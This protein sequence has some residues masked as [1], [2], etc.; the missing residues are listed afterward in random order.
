M[1]KPIK[2]PKIIPD[3]KQT[4]NGNTENKEDLKSHE[5]QVSDNENTEKKKPKKRPK[6]RN[7][8]GGKGNGVKNKKTKKNTAHSDGKENKDKNVSDT[9]VTASTSTA[10]SG[11]LRSRTISTEIPAGPNSSQETQFADKIEDIYRCKI[12]DQTFKR[13]L[14]M[15]K[16][17]LTCT[18][19]GNKFSCEVC[20]KGF[21]QKSYC[22]QHFDFY[23][24]NKPKKFVCTLCEKSFPLKKTLQ[25]HN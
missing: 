5:R 20:G 11:T 14:Q 19:L 6:N 15:K 22:D 7:D 21:T 9:K 12:C 18:K 8:E 16:H 2:K 23:H 4:E 24:T 25:E 13:H 17:K 10:T 3:G 1:K